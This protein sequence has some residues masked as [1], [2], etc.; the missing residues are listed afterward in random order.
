[1]LV[2]GQNLIVAKEQFYA[3]D[4][5]ENISK[6]VDNKQLKGFNYEDNK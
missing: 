3:V 2:D 4:W 6:L 5:D 1:M